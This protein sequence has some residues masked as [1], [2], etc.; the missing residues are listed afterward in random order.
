MDL[1]DKT[2]MKAPKN[3]RYRLLKHS[4]QSRDKSGGS[5]R[6]R[7]RSSR[8]TDYSVQRRN[9]SEPLVPPNPKEFESAYSTSALRAL[10][11]T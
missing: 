9:S 3:R 1:R 7:F 11:G 8:Q 4:P 10:F 6:T 5:G 2:G